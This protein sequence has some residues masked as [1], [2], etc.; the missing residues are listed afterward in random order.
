MQSWGNRLRAA[1]RVP[2]RKCVH[3]CVKIDPGEWHVLQIDAEKDKFAV[4]RKENLI[5]L[6]QAKST[7]SVSIS[8][9]EITVEFESGAR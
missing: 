3:F 7:E 6:H 1:G 4:Y 8:K 9:A 5:Y 2:L